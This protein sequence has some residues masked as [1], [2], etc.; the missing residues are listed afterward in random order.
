MKT[1]ERMEIRT[2]PACGIEY[3]NVPAISRKDNRTL[4]CPDCGIR[5][6]LESLGMSPAE[7]EVVIGYIRTQNVQ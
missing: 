4:I 6:A 7:R 5:E 3:R 2:C 1:K